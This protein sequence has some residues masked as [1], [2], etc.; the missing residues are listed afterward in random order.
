MNDDKK[1]VVMIIICVV[2]LGLAAGITYWTNRDKSSSATITLL[3]ANPQCE[4]TTEYSTEKFQNL[5][6]RLSS[7]ESLTSGQGPTVFPCSHCGKKSCYI[8]KKCDKCGAY[9]I[10]KYDA[11]SQT[12]IDICT[13]CGYGRAMPPVNQP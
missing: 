2:C 5:I 4:K 12:Y 9:F 7:Q 3:C 8:A 13:K 11:N 1:Q 10:P 6:I